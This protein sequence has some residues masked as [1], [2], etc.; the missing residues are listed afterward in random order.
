MS[1]QMSG[2]AR[3][4]KELLRTSTFLGALPDDVLDELLGR[5]H[6]SAFD[7][8]EV[9]CERGDPGDSLM[10]VVSGRLKISNITVDAREVAH[11]FLGP[12]EVIGEIAALDGRGRTA[13]ATALEPTRLLVVYRRD[14]LPTLT[15]HP[16]ALLEIVEVL[17]DKLRLATSVV[18]DSLHDMPRRAA[19]G[20]LR[21]AERH[22][23]KTTA[24]IVIDLKVNQRDL[25][26]FLG[27]SR[28]NTSR[29]LGALRSAGVI[30]VEGALIT[31]IDE[32]GLVRAA[33]NGEAPA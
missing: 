15:S 23:R 31:I 26:N 17:C 24:G 14:L 28:E 25:G 3:A 13:T 19:K 9:V 2:G 11:T 12:G 6:V 29:Q 16:A 21:M 18:E 8:G 5:A 33:G 30:A 22:G 4:H 10:V 32:A 20:L 27:L 7:K 1:G